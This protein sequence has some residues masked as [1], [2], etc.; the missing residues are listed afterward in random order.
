MSDSTPTFLHGFLEVCAG[1]RAGAIAIVGAAFALAS[2]V[3][4]GGAASPAGSAAPSA[5]GAATLERSPESGQVDHVGPA[6]GA[7]AP[8]GIKD[9]AFTSEVD[10]PVSALFLVSVDDQGKPTGQFHADTLTG[11]DEGP[12][13]LGS[14][15]GGQTGGIGVFDG[16]KMLNSADGALPQL[17]AAHRRLTL[18]V[19]PSASVQS[20]TKLRVYVLRPDHSVAAGAIL[21]N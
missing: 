15:L 9:L 18:Y 4:C 20:G 7:L 19:A 2:A 14:K 21:T 1:R 5:G 10:G 13:L 11:Q 12:R 6:D 16:G 8:D 17:G 3:A